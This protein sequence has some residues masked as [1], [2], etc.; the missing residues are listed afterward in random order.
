M[1]SLI[2][3]TAPTCFFYCSSIIT[4]TPEPF[5]LSLAAFVQKSMYLLPAAY[6]KNFSFLSV[7]FVFVIPNIVISSSSA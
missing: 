1:Y 7:R 4:P 5:F 6:V 3:L 2:L